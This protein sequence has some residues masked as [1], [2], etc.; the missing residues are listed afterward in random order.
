MFGEKRQPITMRCCVCKKWHVLRVDLEDI[1][2]H[3]NR[4]PIQYA[5]AD[6]RGRPYLSAAE[7][8]LFLSECC[9]SCWHCSA[10][11]TDWQ[12]MSGDEMPTYRAGDYVN[13]EFPDESTS[14]SRASYASLMLSLYRR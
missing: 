7:R 3:N 9:D 11:A 14:A 12:R 6:R 10:R 8:E 4:V 5:F 13:V 2:R 1:K